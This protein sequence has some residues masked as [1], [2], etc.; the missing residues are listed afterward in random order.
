MYILRSK[1]VN[2]KY[3]FDNHFCFLFFRNVFTVDLQMNK[4]IPLHFKRCELKLLYQKQESKNNIKKYYP[5]ET[6]H[7]ELLF[8]S[9][10]SCSLYDR[11]IKIHSLCKAVVIIVCTNFNYQHFQ[12]LFL[13]IYFNYYYVKVFSQPQS[14]GW[15]YF[16]P[17]ASFPLSTQK[18]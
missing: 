8:F 15:Q 2:C 5:Y 11:N 14:G 12:Y 6:S 3:R 1:S 17:L 18:Q 9:P 7:L 16:Q 10:Y 4:V 13:L